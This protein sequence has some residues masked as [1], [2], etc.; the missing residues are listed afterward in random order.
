LADHIKLRNFDIESAGVSLFSV[1]SIL[2]VLKYIARARSGSLLAR[3]LVVYSAKCSLFGMMLG[4]R[5]KSLALKE[6]T[7][8]KIY[9]RIKILSRVL[10]KIGFCGESSNGRTTVSDTVNPGSSP[11]S[12]ANP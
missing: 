5:P 7:I 12:P 6:T 10:L 1:R 4:D 11:G 8:Y 2:T 9:T 3:V